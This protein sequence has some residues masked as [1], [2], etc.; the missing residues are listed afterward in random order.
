MNTVLYYTLHHNI[1]TLF[2]EILM[3]ERRTTTRTVLYRYIRAVQCV[4]TTALFPI[5][6]KR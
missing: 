4:K 6:R 3:T 2:M 5:L 1:H